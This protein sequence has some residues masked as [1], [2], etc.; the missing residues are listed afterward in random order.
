MTS[1]TGALPARRNAT[2]RGIDARAILED[3]SDGLVVFDRDLRYLYLNR[4]AAAMLG[5]EV[6]SLRGRLYDEEFPEARGTPFERAYREALTDGIP[7]VIEEHYA[8][9]GR[10]FENRIYPTGDG[11]VILFS[12]ITDRKRSE[13]RIRMQADLLESV[14]EAVIATDVQG[15]IEYWGRGAEALYGWTEADALGRSV[16][17]LLQTEMDDAALA[18]SAALVASGRPWRGEVVQ[19]DSEGRALEVDAQ[20]SPRLGPDGAF[21]GMVA[22]NREIGATRRLAADSERRRRRLEAI[23]TLER[24]ILSGLGIDELVGAA[25]SAIRGI[26]GADLVAAFSHGSDMSEIVPLGIDGGPSR[27]LVPGDRVGA[28]ALAPFV[29]AMQRGEMLAVNDYRD[30]DPGPGSLAALVDEGWRSGLRAPLIV[31]GEL[32][33]SVLCLWEQPGEPESADRDALAGVA[34]TL[35]I[36]LKQLDLREQQAL[37]QAALAAHA[38][39]LEERVDERTAELSEINRELDAF[40]YSVSHDLRAPLRAMHGFAAAVIEDESEALTATGRQFLDRIIAAAER[41]ETLIND[42]LEYGR[43]SRIELRPEAVDL[44]DVV[45]HVRVVL[46]AEIASLAAHIDVEAPLGSVRAHPATVT[47]VVANLMS[48]AVKYRQPE[49]EPMIRISARQVDDMIRLS[50]EDDGLGIAPEHLD[51]IFHPFERLHGIEAYA[52]T[53]IGLAVVRRGVERMGGR[54]GVESRLGEG[55]RF[56]IELPGAPE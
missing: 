48:N 11:L 26:I 43:L 2:N 53:G 45:A 8:P 39:E 15:S 9:W 56:W 18:A 40:A 1:G 28:P 14:H 44:D 20:V 34:S 13:Q 19:R 12:E 51:R 21:V 32:L 27:V 35:A 37:A 49:H 10:W 6:D 24:K 30:L 52:G 38:A 17:E 31:E 36:G 4:S 50:V 41:M 54:C 7:R 55:S 3:V 22:T 25:T 5:R 42:L 33:G 29:A 47:H 46:D 16:T 23:H